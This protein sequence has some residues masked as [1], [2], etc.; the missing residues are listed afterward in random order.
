MRIRSKRF[1]S[2][3]TVMTL[4]LL[5]FVAKPAQAAD[6]LFQIVVLQ[7]SSGQI[8]FSIC[9][10]EPDKRIDGN[11]FFWEYR[12]KKGAYSYSGTEP[13][14]DFTGQDLSGAGYA[15]TYVWRPIDDQGVST[16]GLVFRYKPNQ[17]PTPTSGGYYETSH[18]CPFYTGM[19]GVTSTS[20]GS[21]NGEFK[22]ADG[23]ILPGDASRGVTL[24]P[25]TTYT[26]EASIFIRSDSGTNGT[27]YRTSLVTTTDSGCP[28]QAPNELNRG[29]NS[30]SLLAQID[31]NNKV[32]DVRYRGEGESI[33][34]QN[35][36]QTWV[37]SYAAH[38]VKRSAQVGL[39]YDP[40]IQD[41]GPKIDV[42]SI[43]P[44]DVLLDA[45]RL[46]P[47]TCQGLNTEFDLVVD[48]LT[49][50]N[51]KVSNDSIEVV[52]AGPCVVTLTPKSTSNLSL[53]RFSGFSRSL[54]QQ[55][56][57]ERQALMF[58]NPTTSSGGGTPSGGGGSPS[59]GGSSAGVSASGPIPSSSASL[60]KLAPKKTVS[61]KTIANQLGMQIPKKS[62]VT[63]S[64]RKTSK[65]ICRVSKGRVVALKP[66][67]CFVTVSVQAPKP[68]KGKKPKPVKQMT[69]ITVEKKI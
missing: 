68:K 58:L 47:A 63:V 15:D 60:G 17:N 28:I 21:E 42:E 37:P 57:F 4:G 32:V 31:E 41:F 5:G 27:T 8:Q 40:V 7:K 6:E 3:T 30:Y 2:I 54:S 34:N 65:K 56:S 19:G 39:Y 64:V 59:G 50:S 22:L 13:E 35:P 29:E 38:P 44:Q 16:E 25:G 10:N 14:W 69:V 11:G 49:D 23:T 18:N 51:C 45:A 67:A 20:G 61:A 43:V 1:I 52:E 24:E 36:D 62:K 26:L 48:P 9:N 55:S 46:N 33:Q 53:Q 12:V 66:G